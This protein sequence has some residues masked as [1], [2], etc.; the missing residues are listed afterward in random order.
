MGQW[1]WLCALMALSAARSV[2]PKSTGAPLIPC[3]TAIE[4]FTTARLS[5]LSVAFDTSRHV[6]DGL[7]NW[8]VLAYSIDAMFRTSS[9]RFRVC[10]VLFMAFAALVLT[11]RQAYAYIDPGTGSLIYQTLL[12]MILGLGFVLRSARARIGEFVRG[13]LGRRVRPSRSSRDA[14]P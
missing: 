4:G 13:V 12:A 7:V 6:L 9:L 5:T 11:P 3:G 8:M 14:H 1:M 10:W 2:P